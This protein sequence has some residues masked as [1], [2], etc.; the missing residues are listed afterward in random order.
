MNKT[1][2]QLFWKSWGS[3]SIGSK[4]IEKWFLVEKDSTNYKIHISEMNEGNRDR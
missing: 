1:K 4:F 3:E 2:Q